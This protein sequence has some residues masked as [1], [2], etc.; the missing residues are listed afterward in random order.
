MLGKSMRLTFLPI[1]LVN[2]VMRVLSCK[3]LSLFL[4]LKM[5]IKRMSP[6]VLLYNKD[7]LFISRFDDGH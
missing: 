6:E 1:P 2:P 5:A 7:S 4:S 3:I